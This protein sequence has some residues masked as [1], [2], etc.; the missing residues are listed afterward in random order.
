MKNV[1]ID[2]LEQN[3][4]IAA[5]RNEADIDE[6]VRSGVTTIFLMR[7]D[8]FNIKS[9]VDKIK[10][11]GKSAFIHVDFL[12]GLGRDQKAID[13]IT[14]EICPD[15]IISTNSNSIK[16]AHDSGAFT[17]QRFFIVDSQSYKNM[18]GTVKT[19]NPDMIEVMPAI[20]PGIIKRICRQVKIPVI[21][22]GL[23]DSKENIIDTL[24]SG[25]LAVSLGRKDLWTL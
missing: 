5:V 17:I 9:L 4:V 13:Y 19:V 10:S 6:A 23:I 25:A 8:V 18:V 20:M 14:R 1:I 2:R 7:A 22:G 3:P 15:G 24:K 11:N 12:E 16:Y 21:A